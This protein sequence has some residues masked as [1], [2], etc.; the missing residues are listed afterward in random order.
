MSYQNIVNLTEERIKKL[1]VEDFRK[2]MEKA[3]DEEIYL[4][5]KALSAHNMQRIGEC[6]DIIVC[7]IVE[8]QVREELK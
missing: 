2:I 8:G 5:V 6:L 1:S 4:T 7:R 3:T